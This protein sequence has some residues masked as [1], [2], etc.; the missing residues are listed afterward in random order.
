MARL[1]LEGV[2]LY[3]QDSGGPEP[4]L[5]F[6]HGFLMD[7]AM[8][9][10][11]VE[12]LS[13]EFRCIVW[14]QRHHGRTRAVG[15]ST[16]WDSA[17]DVL[18][19]LDHLGL[20]HA[21]L[22]GMSQGGYL[23]LR[24]ALLAPE[25]VRALALID[26]Q[27]TPEDP[28]LKPS[29][30]ELLDQWSSKRVT[31]ALLDTVAAVILGSRVDAQPWKEKWRRLESVS[32]KEIYKTLW[33]REDLAERLP[34]IDRPALVI[35]GSDDIAISIDRGEALCAALPGCQ[36]FIRVEGAGHAANLSHPGPVNEALRDFA[37]RHTA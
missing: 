17:R 30:D 37:R 6:S 26:S 23:S 33:E 35:H 29:Y 13:D 16:Y 4:P 9:D 20:D 18:G 8:F 31:D 28:A 21:I 1:A 14:D 12:A 15:S 2:E 25:K 22:V 19:L 5:V 36:G 24:A 7:H 11:Q 27:A 34:E 32:V 3:F 10:P